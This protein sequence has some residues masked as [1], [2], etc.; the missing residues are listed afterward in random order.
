[1][2]RLKLICFI[3]LLGLTSDFVYSQADTI[4]HHKI[5]VS[6]FNLGFGGGIC[7]KGG[8]IG[9]TSEWTFSNDMAIGVGYKSNLFKSERT[10]D[11][12][13]STNT[14]NIIPPFDYINLIA[15]TLKKEF[16]TSSKNLKIGIEGGPSLSKY[17]FVYFK[18]NPNYPDPNGFENK[19]NRYHST[20]LTVGISIAANTEFVI[21]FG[22]IDLI[23]YTDLNKLKSVIGLL[24]YLNLSIARK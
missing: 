3:M 22:S 12:F 15:I 1:M 20:Q 10:P 7:T 14:W 19:Y 23:L 11:D 16:Q 17:K 4:T 24:L 9:I 8:L 6:G 18:L 13:R 2:K 5:F 21:P